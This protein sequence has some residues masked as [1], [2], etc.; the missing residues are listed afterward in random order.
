MICHVQAEDPKE[1]WYDSQ[2]E[3][4]EQEIRVW[5]REKMDVPTQTG[6][7]LLFPYILFGSTC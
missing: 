7:K 6:G 3:A 2:L 5:R 4:Q 1:T